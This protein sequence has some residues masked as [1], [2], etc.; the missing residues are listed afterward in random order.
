MLTTNNMRYFLWRT[1]AAGTLL[2]VLL[3]GSLERR[4]AAATDEPVFDSAPEAVE[5]L[6]R[7]VASGDQAAIEHLIGRAAS[8][9]DEVQDKADRR[10][11]IEKYSEMHRLLKQPDGTTV[12]YIGAENWPFPVPLVSGGGKWRFDADAGAQEIVYREIGEDESIAIDVSRALAHPDIKTSDQAIVQYAR[13]MAAATDAQPK[14]VFGYQF[15]IQ[16]KS[17][18]VVV[19]AYPK[20]YGSSG[21]MTFLT[22]AAGSIY[23][24]D[25]GPKTAASAQRAASLRPDRT[26]HLT[27][28]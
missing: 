12:L 19:L 20:E 4:L 25:L 13:Q 11:F 18:G 10:Q 23:E 17:T 27:E 14:T 7:A 9:N 15:V 26:W 3:A 28:E 1:F 21:I 6:H 5:A 24:K 8:S 16:R 2:A 22:T